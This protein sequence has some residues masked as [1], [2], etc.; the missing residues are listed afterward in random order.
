MYILLKHLA[1]SK[2]G[3]PLVVIPFIYGIYLTFTSWD[4]VSVEKPFVGLANYAAA[5]GDKEFWLAMGRTIIYSVFSVVL[6][7][8]FAFAMAYLVTSGVK[9]Q[10]FFRAGFFV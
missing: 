8:V 4:G 2:I 9:G 3:F 10:N 1:I 7:N 5:F 6:I